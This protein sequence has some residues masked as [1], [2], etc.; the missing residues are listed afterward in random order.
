MSAGI[1]TYKTDL[2]EIFFT[3]FEQFGFGQV[4]GTAP[5][6]AWGPDEAKAVLTETY[7]FAREV[8]GPLNSVGDREGCRLENGSVFTPK[9]F[10]DAWNKLYEQGFKTVAV[11]PDHGGQGA[12]MMLQVTVEEILSGANTAFNMYP[13]LAFGAAE[14]VAECGTP[15]QQKQFVERML[16]GTWGGT[17]C[18]TEPHAGSD[19]GAAKSTAKRNGDGTYSIKGTKIFISGGDHDMAGNIIHLVLARIDGAPVGTKGLSLFIVP[20]LRIN[21]DGSSGQANDVTVGSIEH[22]MG[23]NGSATCVLNFGENDGCLGELVGTVEHVGMSQMFKMMNGARIA[24]GIQGVSLASAA[25]YNAL[26][27]AKDRKQGSHFTKWKDPSAPRASIIEHPDVR[28]MLLDIKAHVEG[29]RALVI[30]LAMH[31]DKAKQLAGKDDDAATY[32]KGQVEVLTP[33]V[34]SYGSDQ[35]FRLCAQAI[36]VYGGAGYIQDYPVE[37]YTRDSKIFSVYEGTNHIQAMD[38]VGRKMGQ[39]GGAHFQQFMGDVGSF[40]EAHREHPVLGEAVKTLAGAQEGLMSSAMALFGWSQDAGRFPLIPLSANRFLNM[41]SEVAVGWL[42]LDAAV[43][44]EKAAANV[45]ADHPDK[46]FYEGKKFS[47]L[48]YARNVLPNVEY[49]ARLIAT[50][51][52]SPM[53]ITDAAFGGV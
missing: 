40:V 15:E 53:D 2:R 13:G 46:A 5:Y 49:A 10:K 9:G 34:K 39:A 52:T 25:Y 7:R 6:D 17:M 41:M 11:S 27:Y 38:L 1:N 21:A 12:P 26:D 43:I 33:L 3:L 36:Q 37:Q 32:H 18:L 47:A 24:V 48:W 35:A 29:I 22:K 42:L 45:A 51:D 14:V 44:A 31:L 50:E 30:K 20:K 8:L 16:N 23:I 4:A 28:R 19:V